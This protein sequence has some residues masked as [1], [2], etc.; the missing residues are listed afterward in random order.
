M[1]LRRSSSL[2]LTRPSPRA[3]SARRD[4][5]TSSTFL[6]YHKKE[7]PTGKRNKTLECQKQE[8]KVEMVIEDIR[9]KT[10][11]TSNSGVSLSM[12]PNDDDDN[13][14]IG[15]NDQT[16][17]RRK[18]TIRWGRCVLSTVTARTKEGGTEGRGGRGRRKSSMGTGRIDGP[19]WSQG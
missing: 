14:D 12:H 1:F 11:R 6:E 17:I 10:L 9:R 3:N 4:E 8:C 15:C 19:G 7:E 13:N 2:R 16:W 5:D 18:T